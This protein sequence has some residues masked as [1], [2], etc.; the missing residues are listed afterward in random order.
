M[1]GRSIRDIESDPDPIRNDKDFEEFEKLLA[2]EEKKNGKTVPA[3]VPG[4][5][6]SRA[7]KIS[8]K[9]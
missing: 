7:H 9:P 8:G 6:R 3:G 4:A 5:D 2:Q 1:S